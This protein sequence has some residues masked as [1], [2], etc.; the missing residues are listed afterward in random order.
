MVQWLRFCSS[1]AGSQG[2][3]VQSLVSELRSH[4][5][6]GIAKILN[7]N[8][9][10]GVI[11]V[12]ARTMITFGSKEDSWGWDWVAGKVPFLS[13]MVV[14]GEFILFTKLYIVLCDFFF[15]HLCFVLQ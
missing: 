15:L 13:W 7:N 3:S 4:N 10:K 14:R 6:Q 11:N 5:L 12:K 1:N 9:Y 8:K 2:A